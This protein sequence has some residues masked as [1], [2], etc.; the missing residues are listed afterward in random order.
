ML[1]HGTGKFHRPDCAW[2]RQGSGFSKDYDWFDDGTEV[3]TEDTYA[4]ADQACGRCR[5]LEV[6]E[7][8]APVQWES[9]VGTHW[10]RV[11]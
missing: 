7:R 9:M 8:L 6:V 5:S 4:F 1:Y 11:S 2:L 10:E 3:S